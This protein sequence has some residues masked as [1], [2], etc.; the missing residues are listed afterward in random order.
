MLAKNEA[1]LATSRK[2]IILSLLVVLLLVAGGWLYTRPPKPIEIATYAPESAIAYLEINNPSQLL[3][4]LTS[5]RAWQQLAPAYGLSDKLGYIGEASQLGWL[6]GL[7]GNDEMA[8]ASRAQ[9]AVVITSLEARGET[10]KPRMALVAETHSQTAILHK[11]AEKRLPELAQNLFGQARKETSEYGGVQ[12]FSYVSPNIERKLLAAQI[13]GE[14]I[15]A[16]HEEPLRA[17][18]DARLGRA[19]SMTNNVHL[20]K[21]RPE[22][23]S[24]NGENASA[25]GFVTGEGVKRLLR[26]GAYLAAGGVV[27]KSLLAGAV[28]EVFTDFSG[29]TCDGIA[30]GLGFENGRNGLETVDRYAILFKPDLTEK[31]NAIIK[32]NSSEPRAFTVIP[33]AAREVTLINVSNPSQTLDGIEAAISSRVDAA[34]SFLLHQFAIGMREAAFG[35][36]SGELTNAAIGDEIA[37]FNLTGEV[38]HRVWLIAAKDRTMMMRLAEHVLTQFQD[39]RIA[40]MTRENI[41]GVE[42]LNSSEPSRGSAVLFSNFLALGNRDQL[43]RLIESLHTG[44]SL[45]ALPQFVPANQ[46]LSPAPLLSFSSVQEESHEMMMTLARSMGTPSGSIATEALSQLPLAT[47]AIAIKDQGLIIES[48]SPFGNFPFLISLFGSN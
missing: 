34:Q 35:A 38:Q 9:L 10:I 20:A 13:E 6:A 43:L 41:S 25:F 17:C 40:T 19:P 5:T 29:K 48:H 32:T 3:G 7:A 23:R 11:L 33:A 22:V 4:Q 15:L 45:K 21:A 1:M 28:G 31:L 26:L 36:K 18:I 24:V 47:S 14:L 42:I 37:S 8:I 44:Q 27:G 39:K 30:Y 2:K 12:V 16:N 46:A